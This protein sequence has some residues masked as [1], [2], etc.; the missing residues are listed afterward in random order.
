MVSFDFKSFHFNTPGYLRC[1]LP[2]EVR[3]EV[4][5][6][7]KKISN[8]KID[9]EDKRF[10]L[11]G[12]LQK[13]TSF[14]ITKKLKYVVEAMCCHY[15]DIFEMKTINK[16]YHPEFV[17]RFINR[18][19]NFQYV[20]RSL[21]INYGK[22]HDF[23]PPH[24]HSG[25]YSFVL[26]IKIPYSSQDEKKMYS[27]ANGGSKSGIFEFLYPSANY[28]I[29][30]DP[31]STEEWDLVLFPAHLSHTVYPFYTSDEERISI[32]GNLYFEPVKVKKK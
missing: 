29:Q 7:I 17:N 9:T 14:P 16:M 28:F 10:T 23:N 20:L 31:I 21:W 30:A 26:W 13:E 12:H 32:A 15:D 6:T 22:K 1:T 24:T 18:G 2:E 3:K 27:E 11:A 19:Y 4:K 5:N 8:G 25:M